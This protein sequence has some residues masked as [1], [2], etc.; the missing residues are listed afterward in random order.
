MDRPSEDS[1]HRDI[2]Q[3]A[4]VSNLRVCPQCGDYVAV[5]LTN[6]PKD[7]AVL[8]SDIGLGL[9]IT[10]KYEIL[11]ELGRGGFGVVYKA[12]QKYLDK[13]C[14]IKTLHTNKL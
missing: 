14:A 11:C 8:I 5:H 9:A 12:R 6:C 10:E 3:R 4:A 1:A 2:E 7:G 13:L